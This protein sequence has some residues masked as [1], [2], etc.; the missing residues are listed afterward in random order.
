MAET[1]DGPENPR[2][3]W[4][5]R[6]LTVLI[7]LISLGGF[8]A[9]VI[10]SYDTGNAPPA[11][12][13][14]PLIK[15]EKSPVRRRPDKPGGMTVP[16]RDKQVFSRLDP[17]QK[18]PRVENLLPPPENVVDR[19]PPPKAPKGLPVPRPT[20]A[21]SM[22]VKQGNGTPR[23]PAMP[24]ATE[25][26]KLAEIPPPPKARSAGTNPARGG[27]LFR[28]QIASMRSRADTLGSWSRLKKAHPDLFGKLKLT[29]VRDDLGS[30]KGTY[31]RLQAG[32]LAN[33][34]AA[35]SLCSRIKQ[36]KLGC[37]VVRP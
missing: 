31:Y 11:D 27:K 36:R 17:E 25:R 24:I 20:I 7:A 3:P 33:A 32:P 2:S 9:V 29:V 22:D 15:A 21:G 23:S 13:A 4:L 5:R 16:D 1:T 6:G 12:W 18:R 26:P 28:V 19:P 30:V 34:A 14:V 35:R 8:G 37:I 10:W